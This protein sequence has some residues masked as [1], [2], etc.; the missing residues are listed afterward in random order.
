MHPEIKKQWV[1]DL[2]SG[3][4]KQSRGKLFNSSGYCCLGVLATQHPSVDTK[5]IGESLKLLSGGEMN[6]TL[7]N[8]VRAWCGLSMSDQ[9]KLVTLNDSG[10]QDFKQIADYI[11]E[12]L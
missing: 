9:T 5:R 6:G 12:K 11:E 3:K 7:C 8:D 1:K 10:K 4:F 2:R